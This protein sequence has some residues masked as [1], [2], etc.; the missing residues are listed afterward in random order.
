MKKLLPILLLTLAGMQK[1]KAQ[2]C[3]DAGVCTI[4]SIKDNTHHGQKE[5]K[6]DIVV[7]FAFGKGERS[8]TYY[9]PYIE[10]RRGIF[11]STSVSAKVTLSAI[12]GELTNTFGVGDLFVSIDHR[13]KDKSSWSKILIGG[14]KIPFDKSDISKNNIRLPLPYQ[15]SLG[16]TDLILGVGVVHHALGITLALQQPL[17]SRNDNMYLPSDYPASSNASKYLPTNKFGRKGDLL[18]RGSYDFLLSKKFSIR[19]SILSIYH[20]ANDTYADDA[21]NRREIALS[22]GITMNANVFFNYKISKTSSL[23]L[24]LAAPFVVRDARP[25][26]LTRSFVSSLEYKI[27]F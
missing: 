23:E 25:D 3:S 12:S 8:I 10:Y 18:L 6:N 16:T 5:N 1:S 11:K 21:G 9:N 27:G 2:G 22:R 14:I 17:K 4:N 20:L 7:G 13:I 15:T 24:S 26:G 19:P